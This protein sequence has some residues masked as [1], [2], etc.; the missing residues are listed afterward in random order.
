VV[1]IVGK[2]SSL[3]ERR[4]DRLQENGRFGSVIIMDMRIEIKRIEKVV[5]DSSDPA[6]NCEDI[7]KVGKKIDVSL[8]KTPTFLMDTNGSI[9]PGSIITGNLESADESYGAAYSL[10]NVQ[11]ME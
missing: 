2:V 5:K 4:E 7:Y 10:T 9:L 3:K 1:K 6:V 8:E 11:L